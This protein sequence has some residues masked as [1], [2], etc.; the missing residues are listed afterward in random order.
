M[1]EKLKCLKIMYSIYL[2]MSFLNNIISNEKYYFLMTYYTK[3]NIKNWMIWK[4][5][6]LTEF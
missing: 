3:Q 6:N 1:S 5:L 4:L 2:I